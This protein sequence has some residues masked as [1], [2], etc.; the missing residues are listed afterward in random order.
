M[1]TLTCNSFLVAI[2]GPAINMYKRI[3]AASARN[4]RSTAVLAARFLTAC[5]L[6]H[7]QYASS[8][9]DSWKMNKNMKWFLAALQFDSYLV[10]ESK[11]EKDSNMTC[12]WITITLP[13]TSPSSFSLSLR[14]SLCLSLSQKNCDCDCD[15][16]CISGSSPYLSAPYLSACTSTVWT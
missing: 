11:W 4:T 10:F 6:I 5:R 3:R 2:S 13:R 9:C 12:A 16:D 1:L 7:I 8:L 15:C 14:M